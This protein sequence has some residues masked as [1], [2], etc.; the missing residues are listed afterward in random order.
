MLCPETLAASV[1]ALAV[2]IAKNKTADEIEVLSAVFTQLGDT[3]ATI[4]S[5]RALIEARC[6]TNRENG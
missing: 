6:G 1:T 3:L 4:T 2:S 5:Q